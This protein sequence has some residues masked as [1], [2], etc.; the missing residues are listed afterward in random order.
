MTSSAEKYVNEVVNS[1]EDEGGNIEE[2]LVCKLSVVLPCHS[3]SIFQV[4]DSDGE[5]LGLENL[6]FVIF[7]FVHAIVDAPKFRSAVKTGLADLMYYIVLYM[8]IT[9]SQVKNI[10]SFT[11]KVFL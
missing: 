2:V 4:V 11:L 6:V 1:E 5:V 9:D 8:Q 3:S 7:E 10:P